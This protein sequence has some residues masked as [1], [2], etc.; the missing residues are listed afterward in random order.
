MA[1]ITSLFLTLLLLTSC[2]AAAAKTKKDLVLFPVYERY[3]RA[4]SNNDWKMMKSFLAYENVRKIGSKNSSK[5]IA[6]KAVSSMAPK[7]RE[8]IGIKE[9]VSGKTGKLTISKKKKDGSKETGII[10]FI[11]ED[12]RW[13]V[14]KE[15]WQIVGGFKHY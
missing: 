13:K 9:K 8:K 1:R 11:R 12:N 4:A 10:T 3:I 6:I 2:F 15:D 5:K 14:L 7:K